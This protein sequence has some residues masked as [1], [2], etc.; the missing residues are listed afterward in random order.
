MAAP[1]IPPPFP[2]PFV[3]AGGPPPA[4]P[5]FHP[6]IHAMLA[7]PHTPISQPHPLTPAIGDALN[8]LHVLFQVPP[9]PK[10]P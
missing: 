3:H 6:A 5:T 7:Q 8:N 2:T 10:A 1:L 4:P 9:G